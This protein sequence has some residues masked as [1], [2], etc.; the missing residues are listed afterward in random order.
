MILMAGSSGHSVAKFASLAAAQLLRNER[1]S[2]GGKA[3]LRKNMGQEKE[4]DESTDRP[5]AALSLGQLIQWD[6]GG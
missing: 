4:R 6:R 2:G 1:I 5:H 3:G